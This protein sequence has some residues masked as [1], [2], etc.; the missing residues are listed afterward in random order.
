MPTPRWTR[1]SDSAYT[2]EADAIDWL[3]GRLPDSD[4]W[5]GWSNLEFVAQD[6]SVNEVDALVLT[7]TK[8]LLVEI[9]S[10]PAV[11]SGDA[12]PW[13]WQRANGSREVTENPLV[14][15]N[16][17]AKRLAG[18]LKN[19]KAL[20]GKGTPWVEELVLLG[21][22]DTR[23]Q[24]TGPAG[25]RVF[26]RSAPH[27]SERDLA[28]YIAGCA[29][30]GSDGPFNWAYH[31]AVVRG[32]EELGIRKIQRQFVAG[33][34]RLAELLE[35]AGVYQEYEGVHT[36]VEG[37]RR[38]VRVYPWPA[39][40]P[41]TGRRARRDAA[42]REFRLLDRGDMHPGILQAQSLEETERGPAVVFEHPLPAERL[43]TFLV[44][45]GGSTPSSS[46]GA[47]R[48]TCGSGSGSCARSPR[49]SSGRTR[50]G[51]TTGR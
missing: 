14:L 18:L 13:T 41:E 32:I 8:L 30:D 34:W 22:K 38:R 1:V 26:L 19:T 24:F 27:G 21:H 50:R 51:S 43:D 29:H 39:S 5:Q 12:G 35:D 6:G 47:R 48:S 11:V 31:S 20:K 28:A 15:A 25:T 23:V 37:S 7:P 36:K 40:G 42:N 4:A 9:K 44:R 17:K 10:T 2:W 45:R 33:Q 16:R 46:G 49:R 3:A